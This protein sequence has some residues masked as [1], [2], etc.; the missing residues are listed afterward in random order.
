[1]DKTCTPMALDFRHA[2]ETSGQ[3]YRPLVMQLLFNEFKVAL[4]PVSLLDLR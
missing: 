2:C 1:M 3:A 4:Q